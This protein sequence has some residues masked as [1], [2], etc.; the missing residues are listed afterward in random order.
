M[1]EARHFRTPFS[2]QALAGWP[3]G[4]GSLEGVI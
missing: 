2:D 3:S 1:K 4:R